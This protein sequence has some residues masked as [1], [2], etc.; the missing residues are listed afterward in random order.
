MLKELKEWAV[1]VRN[2]ILFE[3]WVNRSLTLPKQVRHD[4]VTFRA[5]YDSN[6]YEY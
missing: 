6:I 2:I 5:C 1:A 4:L 3:Q